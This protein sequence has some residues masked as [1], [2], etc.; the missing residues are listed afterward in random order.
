MTP[1]WPVRDLAQVM[2]T[3]SG[4]ATLANVRAR[5]AVLGRALRDDDLE[6]FTR[7]M[8][9]AAA[10]LSGVEVVEALQA[11]ERAALAL[12]PFFAEYDVLVTPTIAEPVPPLGL[13]DTRDPETMVSLAGRYSALTSPFNITGQPALSLPLAT[14]RSGLPIGVQ[15]TTSFG[16]EDL[17]IRLGSQ[18]EAAQPW[19]ARPVWPPIG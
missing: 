6:P 8:I 16:G 19:D 3:V 12:G 9:D 7:V 17:L 14:D 11:L 13:L 18:I 15:F 2:R 10:G 4:S 5:L 1:P